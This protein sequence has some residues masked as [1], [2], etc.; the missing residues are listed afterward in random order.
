MTEFG[1]QLK[2]WRSARHMSQLQ[3]ALEADVSSRHI[4]FLESGRAGPSRDM[5]LHLSDIL[6]VPPANRNELLNAAG[7][8]AQYRRSDLSE[9]HMKA[10]SNAMTMMLSQHNPFPAVIMDKYWRIVDLNDTGAKLFAGAGLTK[11]DSLLEWTANTTVARD[12]IENWAEVGYHVLVRLRNES[13]AQGGVAELDK[14]A[15]ALAED[16]EVKTY[17]PE[18]TLSPVVSTIY[19]AGPMR[20]AL[21]STYAA[22]GS[23]E[24]LAISDLKIE[25]MF[26]ADAQAEAILRAL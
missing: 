18:P 16:P 25:L 24:D 9:P 6:D 8:A 22:F 17:R 21:I 23:A 14:A 1:S 2:N 19:R 13:R 20:L 3:L 7:F 5:I 26:P 11:G 4:S 10:V 15:A 12:V